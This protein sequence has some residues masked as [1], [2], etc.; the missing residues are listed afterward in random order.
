MPVKSLDAAVIK[1]DIKNTDMIALYF[2]T[3]V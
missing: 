1:A 3:P 2:E